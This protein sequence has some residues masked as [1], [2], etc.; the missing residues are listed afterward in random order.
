MKIEEFKRYLEEGGHSEK[1]IQ[2]RINRLN[3]IEKET[4]KNIDSIVADDWV[5]ELVLNQIKN[6][7]HH[8]N[9]GNAL[10]KYYDYANGHQFSILSFA[11]ASAGSS[12][13]APATTPAN[14]INLDLLSPE[15]MLKLYGA[16]IGELKERKILR[17]NNLPQGDYAEWLVCKTLGLTMAPPSTKGYDAT[18]KGGIRYQIKGLWE[19]EPKKGQRQLS[20]LRDLATGFDDL[21]AVI[22]DRSFEVKAAYRIPL[23]TAEKYS[24]S[25]AYQA[26]KL[27]R[28]SDELLADPSVSDITNLF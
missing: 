7:D 27:L 14:S 4:G 15:D 16:I 26:S 24:H 9:K 1:S 5:M 22:F 23:A 28:L 19:P 6:G 13:I 8:G 12:A 25:N 18:G 17:T 21:I 3:S 11:Q 10:R 20:A 2:S